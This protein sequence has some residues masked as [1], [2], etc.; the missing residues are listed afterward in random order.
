LR[1]DDEQTGSNRI[2][3]RL[4]TI[5]PEPSLSLPTTPFELVR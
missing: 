4:P 3:S 1:P 5:H 2:T